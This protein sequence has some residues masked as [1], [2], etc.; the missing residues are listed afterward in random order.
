MREERRNLKSGSVTLLPLMP[1]KAEPPLAS[2][3][4]VARSGIVDRVFAASGIRL[5]LVRGPAGFG[6][7]TVLLQLRARY[8]RN[9][10]DCAWLN[11]DEAD[12]DLPR[13]LTYLDAVLAPILGRG[14]DADS[15]LDRV[16]AHNAPFV[17]FLDECEHIR[18]PSVAAFVS[19]LI[20]SLPVGAVLVVGTRGVPTIGLARL[21]ARAQLLEID[22][23][24][25]RF[26]SGEA[27][28]FFNHRRGLTLR[29]E[30]VQRLHST[31][32][33]WVAALWL[34]S[35]ALERRADP[36][37]VID[38]VSG[39]NAAIADY[40]AEDV[41]AR[42]DE[43]TREFLLRTCLLDPLTAP[44]CDAVCG[45]GDSA[46]MLARIERA[47]LF[48]SPLDEQR[49]GYRYH[50]LF[51]DFLRARLRA[52]R[53]E[54]VAP[55]CRAAAQWFLEHERPVPAV[56]YALMAGDVEHAL[57]LIDRQIEALLGK[58]R[59]RLLSRWL[60]AVPVQ[61]LDA[62]PRLRLIQ[63]WAVMLTRGPRE[64]L[65][66]AHTIE[67]QPLDDAVANAELLTLRPMLLAMSDQVDEAHAL[68]LERLPQIGPDCGF[69][70]SM[71]LQNLA[72]TS[73]ILGEFRAALDYADQA[74]RL[75]M[76]NAEFSL[77]LVD[78]VEASINLMQGRL[79]HATALLHRAAG[80]TAAHGGATSRNAFSGILL[81][82]ALYEAGDH[83]RAERLLHGY[84]PMMQQ[85][86]VPDQLIV[87]HA[88]LARILEARD[89]ADGA[90]QL[91]TELERIGVHHALPRVV[92]SARVERA[93]H[94]LRR[95][96]VAAARE[97]LNRAGDPKLWR[98]LSTR[99][100][101]ANDLIN[102]PLVNLRWLIGSGARTD[103]IRT[104]KTL[105]EKA[106]QAGLERRAIKLRILMA[107]ALH[108]DGQRKT[109]LR[110]LGKAVRSAGAEGFVSTFQEEG[111][112]VLS[113]L[114]ELSAIRGVAEADASVDALLQRLCQRSARVEPPVPTGPQ[115]EIAEAL[116]RK[117]IQVLEMLAQ[118]HSNNG[119]ADRLFVSESTIRTHLRNINTKL[120]AG[121]RTQAL[122]I[123]RGMGLIP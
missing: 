47:N 86:C 88:V 37:Q 115:I 46:Q 24:Q 98:S 104:A 96:D 89:E 58:G 87:A 4:V 63:A 42:Q 61:A 41:L 111:A 91:L 32:E 14:T 3:N 27:D 28:E 108:R 66:V 26:S 9:G 57:T 54:W 34:A 123:A 40:L 33:G 49:S 94:F 55:V 56:D 51:A 83:A 77:S 100:H 22:P 16:A 112:F 102:K 118:G 15:L 122:V 113:M 31:T 70:R 74:R 18:N 120:Q 36:D 78:A 1:L 64:A 103:A 79:R 84:V 85:L 44:L 13:F 62:R 109:A 81:A 121:N 99:F 110:V 65:V 75:P 73:M 72:N 39:S 17:L 95:G 59:L 5:I 68:A 10:I 60:D 105:V 48:L 50:S 25:L 107:E 45:R 8:A 117:E 101:I 21:R 12:N 7:T 11:I 92:A 35:V 30:Q 80:A 2:A 106:D 119:I 71:V 114:G 69:A 23:Q 52:Q 67:A 116:T 76:A 82:E 90:L 53:P 97:Q 43:A 38:G 20:D 93:S 29:P 6:K 19:Q